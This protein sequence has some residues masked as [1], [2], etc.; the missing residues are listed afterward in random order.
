MTFFQNLWPLLLTFL[1]QKFQPV[2]SIAF[3]YCGWNFCLLWRFGYLYILSTNQNCADSK[4]KSTNQNQE[5]FSDPI[6]IKK[7]AVYGQLLL[8]EKMYSATL[9][10]SFNEKMRQ[11]EIV[12]LMR[13]SA[14]K[15][16]SLILT[17]LKCV[18]NKNVFWKLPIFSFVFF[19]F[20][21]FFYDTGIAEN[22]KVFQISILYYSVQ[23]LLQIKHLSKFQFQTFYALQHFENVSALTKQLCF[24][25]SSSQLSIIIA[26]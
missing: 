18:T 26:V 22:W 24:L 10:R 17:G 19:L 13:Q 5:L 2:I 23:R 1:A 3:L 6:N 12:I 11:Y 9:S 8:N 20:S 15:N 4:I 14:S 21:K 7:N 16:A 25:A